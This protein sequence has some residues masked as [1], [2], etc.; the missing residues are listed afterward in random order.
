MDA[1]KQLEETTLADVGF[2][3]LVHVTTAATVGDAVAAMQAAKV[4]CCAVLAGERLAGI[5][6]ERNLVVRVLGAGLGLDAPVAECMTSDPVTTRPGDRLHDVLARMRAGGFRHLPVVDDAGRPI[7][8][9]SIKRAIRL[10]GRSA[11]DVV[12]NVAPV[13]GMYPARA[14]GG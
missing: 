6:T 1:R 8:T 12:Y 5:F 3:E 2:R 7:G 13:P 10:L 11:H 14:E 9:T 4:G